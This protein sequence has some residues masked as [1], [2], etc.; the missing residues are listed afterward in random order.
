MAIKENDSRGGCRAIVE[1]LRGR[2]GRTR[3]QQLTPG[4]KKHNCAKNLVLPANNR[5]I[6]LSDPYPP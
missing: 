6:L 4:D 3:I 2:L 5:L 1:K